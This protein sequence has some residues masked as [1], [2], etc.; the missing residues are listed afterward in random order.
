M[1]SGGI[2]RP[3]TFLARRIEGLWKPH[4]GLRSVNEGPSCYRCDR[5]Q[6]GRCS[7][8]WY[9][10]PPM[11]AT[12]DFI[13]NVGIYPVVIVLVDAR[14]VPRRALLRRLDPSTDRPFKFGHGHRVLLRRWMK[15]TPNW[16]SSPSIIPLRRFATYGDIAEIVAAADQGSRHVMAR[17]APDAMVARRTR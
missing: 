1:M 15:E 17:L 13:D 16:C 3:T 8:S 10:P 12:R 9:Y 14:G 2:H 11:P 5:R 7:M 4:A 6:Q